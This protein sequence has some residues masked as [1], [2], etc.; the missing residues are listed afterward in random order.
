MQAG[1]KGRTAS[2]DTDAYMRSEILAYSRARGVF[3]G[4]SL[5]GSTLRPD[6]GGNRDLYGRKITTSAII[7]ESSVEAPEGGAT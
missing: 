1:P 6:N 3:A 2:A 7:K 4:L 5:E